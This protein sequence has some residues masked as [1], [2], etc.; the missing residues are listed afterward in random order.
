MNSVLVL[1]LTQ[2]P[3]LKQSSGKAL[4]FRDTVVGHGFR[5]SSSL[6]GTGE[7]AENLLLK[8]TL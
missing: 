8:Y 5:Q 3:G 1:E 2:V 7:Q 4:A 6:W